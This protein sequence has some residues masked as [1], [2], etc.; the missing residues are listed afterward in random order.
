MHIN[1]V[2]IPG[3]RNPMA[4]DKGSDAREQGAVE[5]SHGW[6][7]RSAERVPSGTKVCSVN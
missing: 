6:G 5:S 7:E 3:R 4:I 1:E 2:I